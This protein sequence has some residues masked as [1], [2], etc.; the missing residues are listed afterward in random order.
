MAS[1]NDQVF[2]MWKQQAE[3]GMKLVDA[4]VDVSAK[5]RAMQL[6]AANDTRRRTAEAEKAIG[7]AK[8]AQDIWS[9]QYELTIRNCES[10]ATYWRSVFEAMNELNG[11]ML[12]CVKES[13][14]AARPQGEAPSDKAPLALT[15]PGDLALKLWNDMYRQVD[16]FTRSFASAAVPSAGKAKKQDQPGA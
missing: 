2:E 7:G 9:A 8:S 3:F 1:I 14:P 12:Q 11:R 13:A 16:S 6:A 15:V 10:A 4:M 5:L